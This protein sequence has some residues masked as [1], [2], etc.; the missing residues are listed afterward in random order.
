MLNN[1]DVYQSKD[2]AWTRIRPCDWQN[3]TGVRI[4][5]FTTTP[6]NMTVPS[7]NLWTRHLQQPDNVCFRHNLAGNRVGPRRRNGSQIIISILAVTTYWRHANREHY[8]CPAHSSTPPRPPL[9]IRWL[10]CCLWTS[11]Y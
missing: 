7:L 8:L 3:G 4:L 1:I 2:S 5:V 11:N 9:I 10:S 6:Q